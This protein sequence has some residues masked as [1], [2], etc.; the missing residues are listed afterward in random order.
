MKLKVLTVVGTRPEIIRL[1][2]ILYNFDKCFDHVVVHTNQ[3]YDK[4][5]KDVFFRQL[6]IRKPK[7][8]L[9]IKEKNAINT[10]S[11]ILIEIEK[12]ILIEKPDVFFILGDTNSSLSAIV[13]KK[14]QI[15]IF[16]YEAGNRCFDERV[17][18]EVNR[19]IVDHISD[20]N[21]TYSSFA[22]ENLLNEGRKSDRVIK[23][24]SPLFEVLDYYSNQ[25][26]SNK[27]ISALKLE[28]NNYF[29]ISFHRE[30]NVDNS[31]RLKK[32]LNIVNI[33]AAKYKKRIIISTHPRTQKKLDK[34]KFKINKL[35]TFSKPFGYFEYIKLQ[36]SAL[37]V[38]SDSGS[39]SEEA[40]ILSLKAISLRD[41][42][43]RQEAMTNA[44]IVMSIL[45]KKDFFNSI[46]I[47]LKD[48]YKIQVLDDYKQKDISLK[49]P[50]IIQSYYSFIKREVW[51]TN[52]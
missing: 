19:K 52:L 51:K 37:I 11:K 26:N 36:Q 14:Y 28:H 13:A 7:Y 38:I 15:P 45:N 30:E 50:R 32:F 48:N 46:N 22:K 43:E 5:L 34:L 33:L 29:L 9:K 31:I 25:I 3:N 44:T 27:I 20:I 41:T 47:L 2:R 17:P 6:K 18:E 10:I 42:Q 12:I 1:S 16:H 8:D 4:N 39:I 49:L 23:I 24:G 40:S 21:L 35:V